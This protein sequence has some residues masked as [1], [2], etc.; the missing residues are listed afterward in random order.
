M[1]NVTI[2]DESIEEMLDVCLLVAHVYIVHLVNNMYEQH[3][4]T[5]ADMFWC[6]YS[7]HC[8][9]LLFLCSLLIIYLNHSSYYVE[10]FVVT[11]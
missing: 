4:C 10:L 8:C 11:R 9:N 5:S 2:K 6:A 3:R 7:M 1:D